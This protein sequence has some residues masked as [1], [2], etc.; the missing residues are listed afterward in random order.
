MVQ[1]VRVAVPLDV[2][3]VDG[4]HVTSALG[5]SK[6]AVPPLVLN[7]SLFA[8]P[9]AS[10]LLSAVAVI[11]M[12][13]ADGEPNVAPVRMASTVP[14]LVWTSIVPPAPT[15]V[16]RA[17]NCEFFAVEVRIVIATLYLLG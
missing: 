16:E 15:E 3:E 9:V 11:V 1:L 13:P 10:L 7:T 4:D 14:P 17:D 8:V 2:T 12:E 6:I 5:T